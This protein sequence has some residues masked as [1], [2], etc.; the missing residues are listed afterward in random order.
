MSSAPP[1]GRWLPS[2]R[3]AMTAFLVLQAGVAA[4]VFSEHI[5]RAV[6][7]RGRNEV[8]TIPTEPVAPGDQTRPYSPAGVPSRPDGA[9][10]TGS[11]IRLPDALP[12]RLTFAVVETDEAGPVLLMSGEIDTRAAE[13]FRGFLADADELPETVALHSPGGSVAAALEIGRMIRERGLNTLMSADAACLSAC[14]YILAGGVERRVSAL[15]W[16][17]LHQ[18]YFDQSVVIPAYFAVR[19]IQA[20]QAEVM[21]YLAD[22]GVDPLIVV[23]ALR[24]PP[25]DIYLLVEDELLSYRLATAMVP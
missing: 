14:P 23:P 21:A 9:P 17:G 19:T 12:T 5:W 10:G 25:E 22:M 11:P 15:A 1:T 2:V 13:R 16:V 18:S 20:G 3:S 7:F 8:R 4:L 24:T 6:E